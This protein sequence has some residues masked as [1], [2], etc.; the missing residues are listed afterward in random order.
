MSPQAPESPNAPL[1]LAV[2][3]GG[4]LGRIHAKLAS[5]SDQFEVVAIADPSFDSRELVEQQ[6][7][8]PSVEDYHS[9][10]GKI[11]AAVVAAPTLAHY[12][13]TST[14][15]RAGVHCLVEK[16]LALSADQSQRLVQIAAN[17]RRIL[18]VGHVERFNPMWTVAQSEIGSPK[19]IEATRFGPYS[20]RSTDIGVVL[21]LMVHDL[22]LILSLDR[23]E[24][25]SIQ[26]SGVAVLG[27]HEDIAEARIEFES[28]CI[29]NVKASRIAQ[30]PTRRMQVYSSTGFADIDFSGESVEVVSPSAEVISR[31]VHLDELPAADRME[32][33]NTV[34][35]ELFK[36]RS[37]PAPKRNAILDEQND[38]ALSI[39]TGAAPSVTGEDGA[40]AV[41]VAR[42]IIEQ[43]Q[44]HAWDGP[45]SKP[46]RVG[47]LA[48]EGPRILPMPERATEQD[49][50]TRRAG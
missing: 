28:G 8:L 3:G 16:P 27:S 25:H 45:A 5:G 24:V 43:I 38:F 9:L 22:D 15:L 37:L 36:S 18:Q 50:P 23:S 41:Q 40:R 21:D 46:W 19:F 4:H 1:R 42:E 31:A 10:I 47:P 33:R 6:L 2:I 32:A 13:I 7:G 14:L 26:A 44:A 11:D 49:K 48:T 29:A 17:H 34:Y 35:G 20:G 39:Q 12:E 30:N